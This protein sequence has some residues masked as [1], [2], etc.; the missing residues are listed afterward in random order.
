[1]KN[2]NKDVK[3]VVMVHIL[4]IGVNPWLAL[5][6]KIN[7]LCLNLLLIMEYLPI[8]EEMICNVYCC[9]DMINREM[10]SKKSY[11][12]NFKNTNTVKKA[13][14]VLL[15]MIFYSNLLILRLCHN[16]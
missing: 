1:M 4:D 13:F 3:Q 7:L 11:L 2:L 8:K 5:I 12:I 15:I 16:N 10:I 9:I 14:I 6:M